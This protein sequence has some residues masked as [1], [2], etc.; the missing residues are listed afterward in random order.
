MVRTSAWFAAAIATLAALPTPAGAA[1]AAREP[2]TYADSVPLVFV[3]RAL[4]GEQT[5]GDGPLVAPA[6]FAVVAYEKGAGPRERLV[7]TG[8]RREGGVAEGIDAR[9]GELWRIYGEERDGVVE[10]GVCWGSHRV[11]EPLDPFVVRV[12]GRSIT[13]LPST[14]AGDT[15]PTP[16][17][18]VRTRAAV[19][20]VVTGRPVAS[21]RVVRRGRVLAIGVSGPD[22]RAWTVKVPRGSSRLVL[23]TGDRA[24]AGALSRLSHR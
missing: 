8:Y 23:D 18:R 6:R 13:P 22:R 20:K 10:T 4:D 12:A 19:L 5:R 16:A 3:G 21:V 9:P 24:Y 11:A 2:A 17:P 7:D 15:F 1:C 14:L